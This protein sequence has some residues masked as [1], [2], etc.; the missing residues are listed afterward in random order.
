MDLIDWL[1]SE[2]AARGWG[3]NAF[4]RRA[5][6][7]KSSVSDTLNGKRRVTFEFCVGVARACR[8][9]PVAVLRQAG[10]LPPDPQA[11]PVAAQVA[12]LVAALPPAAQQEVLRYVQYVHAQY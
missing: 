1:K 11:D 7:P 10:L 2:L 4:A 12:T 6:L 9:E 8:A 5:G 3:N